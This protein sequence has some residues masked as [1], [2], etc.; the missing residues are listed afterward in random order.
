MVKADTWEQQKK[1][2]DEADYVIL[3]WGYQTAK[4]PIKSADEKDVNLEA[5][6]VGTQFDIDN[7]F[8][9]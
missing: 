5:K 8:R 4:I 3:A 7:K 6:V 1:Y 2:T 9:L